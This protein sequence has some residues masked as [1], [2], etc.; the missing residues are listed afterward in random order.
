MAV[1]KIDFGTLRYKRLK[2][3]QTEW[4]DVIPVAV[5]LWEDV[6]PVAPISFQFNLEILL[7]L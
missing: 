7:K 3:H 6:T 1:G 2:F 5:E 4:E